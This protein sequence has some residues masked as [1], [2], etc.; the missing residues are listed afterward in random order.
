MTVSILEVS[1]DQFVTANGI[2]LHYVDWSSEAGGWRP[3]VVLLHSGLGSGH[4]WDLVGPQ[5]ASAGFH[6]LAP[7]MRG[8][9]RS[10][11]PPGGYD[12]RTI[13][14]DIFHFIQAVCPERVTVVGHS[15]GGYVALVLAALYPNLL[16][17]L[18]LVDGGI[19]SSEGQ[20][21]EQFSLEMQQTTWTYPSLSAY[22]DTQ[23]ESAGLFWSPEVA[24]AL[25]TTVQTEPDGAVRECMTPAAWEQTL[26][27]MW[28]YRPE[29][30]YPHI[31]CPTLVVVTEMPNIFPKEMRNHKLAMNEKFLPE[32]M[33]G[34]RSCRIQVMEQTHHEVP[35]HKPVELANLITSFMRSV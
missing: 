12:L 21:W 28:R 22:L 32:A 33:A 11:R 3:P 6:A 14:E 4:C 30:L 35:F 29:S 10:A 17:K 23:R 26:L 20:S 18:V 27:S 9:G 16:S 25:V 31:A 5:L 8:R 24:R 19:W 7:D 15:Y 2:Q 34:L 13:A 1:T